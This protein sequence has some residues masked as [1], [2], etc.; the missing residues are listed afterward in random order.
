M[1]VKIREKFATQ[2]NS[3]ILSEVRVIAHPA[4]LTTMHVYVRAHRQNC[5]VSRFKPQRLETAEGA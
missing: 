4:Q 2:V 5:P 1:A 3:E